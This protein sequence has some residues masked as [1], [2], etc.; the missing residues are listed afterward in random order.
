MAPTKPTNPAGPKPP[1]NPGTFAGE[2]KEVFWYDKSNPN[3]RGNPT[4]TRELFRWDG[5]AWTVTTG[6]EKIQA[7]ND[8]VEQDRQRREQ[9]YDA[10]VAFAA[11]VDTP[12]NFISTTLKQLPTPSTS[13][14]TDGVLRYPESAVGGGA[15]TE[16]SDYVLFE[17]YEYAP[18]FRKQDNKTEPPTFTGPDRR[19]PQQKRKN[20]RANSGVKTLPRNYYDYNQAQ[21]YKPA[22]VNYKPIIMYMPEDIS[23][24]FKSNWGGKAFSNIATDLLKAAGAEGLNKLEGLGTGVENASERLAAISGAAVI[25][26][27]IQKITGDVLSNDDVFGSIS[28]A[29]LNPNTELLYSA[30]DMRNFQ[31]NFKLVPRNEDEAI[32]INKITKIFKMCTLPSRDPGEVFATKNQGIKSG[33]IGVPKLVRVSFMQGPGVHPV[34]P[35]YKMCAVT[36]IDVNYTPDG[37]YATYTSGQPVAISLSINFQETKMV[38]SEE[39]E[40]DSIR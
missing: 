13:T 16:D 40:R 7:N 33:F 28:G 6:E 27:G 35:V 31:M 17:F 22:G 9:E 37:A 2:V 25:R 21:D 18:P 14:T 8:H 36:S 39:I 20:I 10:R 1:S 30:T 29:I 24:G 23:T 5:R 38:F 3:G 32:T 34:L 4:R 26:K 15:I 11:S 19:N 12:A